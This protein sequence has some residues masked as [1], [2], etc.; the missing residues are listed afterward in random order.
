M[1]IMAKTSDAVKSA[2]SSSV[3]FVDQNKTKLLGLLIITVNYLQLPANADVLNQLMSP[4]AFVVVNMVL[5]LF[6]L[7]FGFLNNPESTTKKE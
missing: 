1:E 3:S 4:T 2:T 7:W 5:G 6:A